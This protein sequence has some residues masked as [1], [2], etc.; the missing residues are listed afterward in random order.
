MPTLLLSSEYDSDGGLESLGPYD[1]SGDF[2][3]SGMPT[4]TAARTQLMQQ[5]VEL[6]E[7]ERERRRDQRRDTETISKLQ[8][9]NAALRLLGGC[10]TAP[11]PRSGSTVHFTQFSCSL[12]RAVRWSRD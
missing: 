5:G 2:G 8:N 6:S 1:R 12:Q 11:G 3:S 7:I 9:E 10:L 4:P